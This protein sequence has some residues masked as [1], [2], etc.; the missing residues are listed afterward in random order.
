MPV[1]SLHSSV[2]RWPDAGAVERA[3]NEWISRQAA[4]RPELLRLGVFGSFA[5]RTDWGVGSDLDLVAVVAESDRPFAERA[6][7]WDLTSLPV[8]AE[9]LVYTEDE[10]QRLMAQGGRFADTMASEGVWLFERE[11]AGRAR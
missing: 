7:D 3:L 10:W 1:R 2:L 5:R 4:Q 8:P 9:L 6:R 11:G